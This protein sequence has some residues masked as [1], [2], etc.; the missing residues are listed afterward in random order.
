MNIRKDLTEQEK[1]FIRDHFA[2]IPVRLL[3][4][5]MKRG[6]V[7]IYDFV[8]AENL[9]VVDGSRRSTKNHPWLKANYQLGIDRRE[10]NVVR[11]KCGRDL[12]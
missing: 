1:Q 10:D 8:K 11:K 7:T 9:V 6:A 4:K 12:K 5:Q 3:A 2:K